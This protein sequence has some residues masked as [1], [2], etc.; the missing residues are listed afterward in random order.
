MWQPPQYFVNQLGR[1][2]ALQGEMVDDDCAQGGA[3]EPNGG[4]QD[5]NADSVHPATVAAVPV[6]IDMRGRAGIHPRHPSLSQA[7][8]L[9]RLGVVEARRPLEDKFSGQRLGG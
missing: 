3:D 8:W 7:V 9:R 1:R 4:A 6:G 2:L 5:Q